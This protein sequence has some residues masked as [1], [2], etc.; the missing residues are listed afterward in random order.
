MCWRYRR[1]R[2]RSGALQVVG[3]ARVGVEAQ[4]VAGGDRGAGRDGLIGA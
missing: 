3:V 1:N 2:T 4:Q